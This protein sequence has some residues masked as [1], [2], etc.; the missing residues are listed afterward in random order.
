MDSEHV[1]ELAELYALG[2]LEPDAVVSVTL[3]EFVIVT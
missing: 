1:D 2:A 3:S